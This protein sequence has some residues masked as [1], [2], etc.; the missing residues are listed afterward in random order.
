MNQDTNGDDKCDLNCDI[1]GDEWPDKNI[2]LD[3]DGKPDLNI[4]TNGNGN[5]D[6]NLDIDKDGKCDVNCDTDGDGKGDW[7][8]MN[9]DTNGDGKCDL[10]CDTDGDEWPD[11]NID[12]DG[13][14]KPDLN[15][16][17]NGNGKCDINCDTNKDGKCDYNCD[18]NGDGKC[19]T[20]CNET[21]IIIGENF[22]IKDLIV[23]QAKDIGPGWN[24]S[25]T[26]KII[27]NTS[28]TVNYNLRWKNVINTFTY[29]NNLD[30]TITRNGNLAGT[31]KTPY[32]ESNLL[33][34]ETIGPN[35]EITYTINYEFK[36]NNQNQNIDQGKL[37]STNLELIV[38]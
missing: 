28:D 1:D 13:D 8:K 2:D 9:Q 35:S 25:Q 38:K 22:F 15:I 5:P 30:Y 20:K 31:S 26:F 23:L 16:D 11:K 29:D 19:D 14:G 3:G 32:I 10:N 37:F 7:N 12:L 18:M 27:N 36:E 4:D 17:T 34:N 33:E 24:G 6:T 21:E